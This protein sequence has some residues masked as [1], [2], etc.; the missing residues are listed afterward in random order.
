MHRLAVILQAYDYDIIYRPGKANGNADK[1]S[2]LPLDVVPFVDAKEEA[3]INAVKLE[4][5]G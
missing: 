2:R 3:E 1:L 4:F 5:F